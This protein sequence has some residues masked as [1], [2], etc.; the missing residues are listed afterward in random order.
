MP[1]RKKASESCETRRP[2]DVKALKEEN[3]GNGTNFLR[4]FIC[5]K[6]QAAKTK[7]WVV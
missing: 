6:R 3:E 7:M 4:L 1:M 2:G 5:R